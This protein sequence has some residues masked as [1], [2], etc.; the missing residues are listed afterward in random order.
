MTK[1]EYSLLMWKKLEDKDIYFEHLS[2]DEAKEIEKVIDVAFN[3]HVVN[4]ILTQ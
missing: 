3:I 2:F 4:Y 1:T